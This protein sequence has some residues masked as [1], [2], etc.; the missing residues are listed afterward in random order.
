MPGTR[1]AHALP[2]HIGHTVQKASII[3]LALSRISFILVSVSLWCLVMAW[4]Y[5]RR[6][7]E[8]EQK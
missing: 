3:F 2:L 5:E 7:A 4:Q 8:Y 6:Q 1:P